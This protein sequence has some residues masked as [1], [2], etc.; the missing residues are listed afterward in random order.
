MRKELVLDLFVL[1]F[2]MY[3][4]PTAT[5]FKT[6]DGIDNTTA[7]AVGSFSSRG[8][9]QVDPDILKVWS[10]SDFKSLVKKSDFFL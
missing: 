4:S 9:S 10:M 8:P 1:F 2:E 6:V 7:P 5:I 3:V